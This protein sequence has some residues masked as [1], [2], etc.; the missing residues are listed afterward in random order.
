MR[1]DGCLTRFLLSLLQQEKTSRKPLFYPQGGGD[2]YNSLISARICTPAQKRV[3][4]LLIDA[5]VTICYDRLTYERV[6]NIHHT[7]TYTPSLSRQ[8]TGGKRS[9][10][11][12]CIME[13]TFHSLYTL[14]RLNRSRKIIICLS[15]EVFRRFAWLSRNILKNSALGSKIKRM[16][17]LCYSVN[18]FRL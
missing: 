16:S 18:I 7:E 12:R 1:V 5:G 9:Q 4:A 15:I 11:K 6:R 17:S 3:Y 13:M 2:G 14:M 8:R 10:A